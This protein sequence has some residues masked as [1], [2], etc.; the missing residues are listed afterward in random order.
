MDVPSGER[1]VRRRIIAGN[2]KMHMTRDEAGRLAHAVREG[3]GGGALAA[4]VVLCPPFTALETVRAA[5][6]G[7]RISLGAQNLFWEASGAWTGEVSPAMV[8][9][10]GANYVIVGHSERRQHFGETNDT[11]RRRLAAALGVGLIPILCVGETGDE[12]EI[13][14][15][16]DVVGRQV[17]EALNGRTA[18]EARRMVI[19]YE[20]VWAIGTGLNA[21]G[22]DANAVHKQIRQI[23]KGKFGDAVSE[24]V[25]IQYGGSVKADNIEDFLSQSDVDGALVGGASLNAESFLKI[26]RAA[27]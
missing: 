18:D 19:A 7:S 14:A 22:Y 21:S 20:P 2:W 24:A 3:L 15:T 6:E 25:R 13:G 27:T 1:N 12:R 16:E 23:L 26:V 8:V 11:A 5:I 9:D 4:D 17:L 10:A